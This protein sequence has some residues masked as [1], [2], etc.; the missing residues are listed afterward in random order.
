M[1]STFAVPLAICYLP[2]CQRPLVQRGNC[3]RG[4]EPG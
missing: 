1:R 4:G 2:M 3:L